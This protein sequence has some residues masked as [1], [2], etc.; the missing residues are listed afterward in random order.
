MDRIMED[1]VSGNAVPPGALPE[2]VRDDVP[3]NASE[4]EFVVPADVVRFL[5]LDKLE[6]MISKA[7]ESLA[8]LDANGRI[9]GDTEDDEEE[10]LPF[11]MEELMAIDEGEGAETPS[12]AE[13]GMV[14]GEGQNPLPMFNQDN[15][16][17]GIKTFKTP[18]GRIAS[19]PYTNGEP[20][21]TLP[22]G[23]EE[24][25]PTAPPESQT[26]PEEGSQRPIG[27][28]QQTPSGNNVGPRGNT[29]TERKDQGSPLAGDP[30]KWSVDNFIDFGK[31]RGSVANKAIG[32]M[33]S[34]MG[35][36]GM[37][38]KARNS[39]LDQQTAE[40]YDQM[41]EEGKDL[42]GNLLTSEQMTQ[43]GQTREQIKED[44]SKISG[45]SLNPFKT[46]TQ[47]AIKFNDFVVGNKAP[48]TSSLNETYA[49]SSSDSRGVPYKS[50]STT[51]AQGNITS[52]SR[53]AARPSSLSVGPS[54]SDNDNPSGET[55][56]GRTQQESSR[57]HGGLYRKGGLIKRRK[58]A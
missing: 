3:I 38:M 19:V 54:G 31:Q 47:A 34:L 55:I 5:G 27:A 10:E 20:L 6:K 37:A 21:F 24:V 51:D 1:E 56:G 48:T 41:L 53:P 4:G 8:E 43:L 30:S 29:D 33:G 32:A 39:I 49:P 14:E 15:G 28:P 16:F 13:G 9:G 40:L 12:F 50:T 36:I 17:T 35:P 2:E 23:Y 44:M 26:A 52:Q 18:D 57:T 46:L 11:G 22:S 7:K 45:L 42:Q 25:S 58:K